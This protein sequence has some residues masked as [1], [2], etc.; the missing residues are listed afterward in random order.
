MIRENL[1]WKVEKKISLQYFLRLFQGVSLCFLA[2]ALIYW[3]GEGANAVREGMELCF[4][5]IIPSMFPFFI[6]SNMVILMGFSHSLGQMFALIMQPVFRVPAPCGTAWVLGLVG[7]YP[8]GAKTTVSLLETGQCTKE[9]GE[10]LLAFTNNAG[11]AFLFGVIGSGMFQSVAVGGMLYLSHIVASVTVGALLGIW[12]GKRIGARVE[13]VDCAVK[14][15]TE[16][17]SFLSAFLESVT[18]AMESTLQVCAFILCFT[19][20]IRLFTLG[21]MITFFASS[22]A[23]IWEPLGFCSEFAYPFV[24]GILELASG[25]TSVSG[26]TFS[27]QMA[28]LSFFLGWGGCSVHGQTFSFLKDTALTGKYY[29]GGKFFQGIFSAVYSYM[30]SKLW[31]SSEMMPYLG[32]EEETSLSAFAPSFLQ[33]AWK[34][35]FLPPILVGLFLSFYFL[36]KRGRK[37]NRNGVY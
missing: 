17:T 31:F 14:K 4:Q 15:V 27:G 34:I 20:L 29:L 21:G 11:P 28:L 2:V 18:K 35:T 6:L 37:V 16:D 19:V 36:Q 25:V 26:G 8:V 10:R 22:L 30:L 33:E 23:F 5:V 12:K 7:G 32:L 13:S 24:L 3:G 1:G 9:E